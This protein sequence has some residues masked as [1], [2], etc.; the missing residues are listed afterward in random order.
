[1]AN[2]L[3]KLVIARMISCK[4]LSQKVTSLQVLRLNDAAFCRA[5]ASPYKVT[6]SDMMPVV[7]SCSCLKPETVDTIPPPVPPTPL[8][9]LPEANETTQNGV[10]KGRIGK[11]PNPRRKKSIV[12]EEAV[13]AVRS[14][15]AQVQSH[16]T[17]PPNGGGNGMNIPSRTPCTDPGWQAFDILIGPVPT[18]QDIGV[19]KRLVSHDEPPA[20]PNQPFSQTISEV[21]NHWPQRISGSPLISP[22]VGGIDHLSLSQNS[23]PSFPPTNSDFTVAHAHF[24]G[25]PPFMDPFPKPPPNFFA[26][27]PS[28]LTPIPQQS[29]ALFA[30][31]Q[32]PYNRLPN[33]NAPLHGGGP[34][35]HAKGAVPA[36]ILANTTASVGHREVTVTVELTQ[37]EWL[38]VQQARAAGVDFAELANSIRSGQLSFITTRS[39]CASGTDGSNLSSSANSPYTNSAHSSPPATNRTGCCS[40]KI[41]SPPPPPFTSHG[42]GCCGGK[43]Q[44][45]QT[46]EK[47]LAT[48]NSPRCKCGEAC[49]CVPCADH[50]H[51]PAM[52]AHIRE[53]MELMDAPQQ[54]IFD[55]PLGG[56]NGGMSSG[57]SP[58][59]P[60]AYDGYYDDGDGDA[61]QDSMGDFNDFVICDYKYGTGC[62]KGMGGCKCGEGC[63]CIGCLTHGGH[64]GVLLDMKS[65]SGEKGGGDEGGG[66]R[67]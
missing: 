44:Q 8:P 3:K 12:S 41:K 27:A 53:N 26:Q 48:S 52:L 25:N 61:P 21:N 43:Q 42:G 39:Q 2:P 67:G 66:V 63:T 49:R 14:K 16:K 51:N 13:E 62:S 28:N 24:E 60:L 31:S 23:A 19:M 15:V 56:E 54:G 37:P 17:G 4:L 50:P 34:H 57:F 30:P 6:G 18:Q 65:T 33:P 10:K 45:S 11:R 29:V 20:D 40:T 9:T 1:M 59:R 38:A 64:D 7:K 35:G 46:P 22:T 36:P 5:P 47:M 55:P 58:D 32:S